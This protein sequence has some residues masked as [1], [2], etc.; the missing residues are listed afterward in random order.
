LVLELI[1]TGNRD[2]KDLGRVRASRRGNA[3]KYSETKFPAV[4]KEEKQFEDYLHNAER[5]VQVEFERSRDPTLLAMLRG[6]N[7]R[8]PIKTKEVLAGKGF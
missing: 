6:K 5:E 3:R 1:V 8:F 4:K 2:I 7:I